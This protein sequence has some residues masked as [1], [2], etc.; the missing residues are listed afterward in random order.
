[1]VFGWGKK[2]QEKK[3]EPIPT[4]KTI[5]IDDVP[6]TVKDLVILREKQLISEVS[7]FIKKINPQIKELAKITKELEKD[8]LKV[9]DIDKH[10]RIIVV[11]GKKQVIEIMK[12]EIKELPSVSN[13]DDVNQVNTLLNQILK[14][15]GDALGR[16]TRV[17]HIF[18]KKYAD[19]LK[20]I[21]EDI[22]QSHKEIQTLIKNYDTTKDY[23]ESIVNNY[24]KLNEYEREV[25]GNLTKKNEL[26][27]EHEKIEAEIKTKLS[28]IAKIKESDQYHQYLKLKDDLSELERVK[29]QLKNEI[30]LQFTKISRPL[31][32]YEYVAAIDKDQKIILRN[33]I[34]DPI[35]VI[36]NENKNS[37]IIILENI[38]KEITSGSISV[39]DV[40]KTMSMLTETVEKLDDYISKISKH[41][42][43]KNDLLT[44]AS[45][46]KPKKLDEL[47]QTLQHLR[48]KKEEV[49]IKLSRTEEYIDTATTSIPNLKK[50][51][52]DELQKFSNTKYILSN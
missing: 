25:S 12:K 16:H 38:R 40:E 1:M 28:D 21:L 49:E 19:K 32:R 10:L 22:N 37:I 52:Q 6:K 50:S 30:D 26:K 51:I 46:V 7:F 42:S 9:D 39:K 36:N 44:Q 20:E 34:S 14:K 4:T 45:S 35:S 13:V 5:P 27:S 2:K 17:I 8:D 3:T 43:S 47:E 15:I 24:N 23:S 48:T 29:S 33:L 11:R 18:A 41:N 31:N